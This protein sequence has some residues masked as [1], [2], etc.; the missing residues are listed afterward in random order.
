M[1]D[2]K[3]GVF[4]P[5]I[6]TALVTPFLSGGIDAASYT[7][8]LEIQ[9]YSRV[10]GVVVLGTTGEAPT[11]TQ[12]EKDV[13]ISESVRVLKGKKTVTVGCGSNDTSAACEAAKRAASLGTE[14][15]LVVAPY[16]NKPSQRGLLRHFIAVADASPIPVVV[17][18]VPSRTGVDI[19]AETLSVLSE[20]PNIA[21]CKEA[22][23]D[24]QSITGKAATARLDLFCGNDAMLLSELA[25][26]AKGAVSVC[27]NI[28]PDRTCEIY[29]KYVSGDLDGAKDAFFAFYPFLSALGCETNPVPIKA[30]MS[31]CGL[32]SD[33][34][35]QPL[36]RMSEQKKAGLLYAAADAGIYIK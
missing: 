36:C 31:A 3:T 18:N 30:V 11:V 22:G 5:G 13:L 14:F 10:A 24:I 7:R 2:K 32:I 12:K 25:L 15:A 19:S 27:S 28:E 1:S 26:G 16:Y 29:E 20:H 23:T 35:R 21:A 9:L 6:H 8:L 4:P 34:V 17:Y 33:A